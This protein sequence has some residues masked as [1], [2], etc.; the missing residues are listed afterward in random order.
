MN[1]LVSDEDKNFST[2][3]ELILKDKK[4]SI[5]YVESNSEAIM[6]AAENKYD[7]ILMNI[8]TTNMSGYDA[9]T[10]IKTHRPAT[11]IIGS[12]TTSKISKKYKHLN[13]DPFDA[14]FNKNDNI[15]NLKSLI[16]FFI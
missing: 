6:K 16:N 5:D 4:Y 15:N 7:V 11:S 2:L 14:F 12:S 3:I 1:I 9:A 13:Y 10:I 8:Q